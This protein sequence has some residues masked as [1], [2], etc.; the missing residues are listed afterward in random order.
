MACSGA[1]TLLNLKDSVI[2]RHGVIFYNLWMT[3]LSYT[4]HDAVD[5]DLIRLM[6][7]IFT[8]SSLLTA[9]DWETA[10]NFMYSEIPTETTSMPWPIKAFPALSNWRGCF[11]VPYF[12]SS[13][14]CLPLLKDAFLFLVLF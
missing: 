1:C 14:L 4:M 10:A 3:D 13:F 6:F 2:Q 9:D 11:D 5:K 8:M 7:G 12:R